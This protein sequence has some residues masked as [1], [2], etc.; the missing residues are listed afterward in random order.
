MTS[1]AGS[2][3]AER[4]AAPDTRRSGV[5]ADHAPETAPPGAADAVLAALADSAGWLRAEAALRNSEAWLHSILETSPDLICVID[6]EGRYRYINSA[7]ERTLGYTPDQLVGRPAR[8]IVHPDDT[9]QLAGRFRLLP[10][11][12]NRRGDLAH[13]LDFTCRTRHADGGWRDMEAK[14]RV[15]TNAD[16]GFGGVLIVSRDVTD[17][18]RMEAALRQSE[19]HYRALAESTSAIVWRAKPDGR[20]DYFNNRWFSFTGLTP[21][22]DELV[23]TCVVHPDDLPAIQRSWAE[24]MAV[25]DAWEMEYRLRGADGVYRWFLGRSVPVQRADHAV[26]YWVGSAIDITERILAEHRQRT[27]YA[28][29]RVLAEATTIEESLTGLLRVLC[30]GL[31]W[32]TGEF[33]QEDARLQT[34]RRACEWPTPAPATIAERFR[35]ETTFRRGEGLPGAAWLSGEPVWQAGPSA[36]AID[37][38]DGADR[39]GQ[40]ST[41][42]FPVRDGHRIIGVLLFTGPGDQAPD[43]PS[44]ELMDDIG[45][46]VGQS[47]ARREAETDR[48]KLLAQE[49]AARLAAQAAAESLRRLQTITDTA[50][51]DL[52]AETLQQELLLRVR[53][54]LGTDAAILYLARPEDETLEVAAASGRD[55]PPDERVLP[56]GAGI[57]GRVAATRQPLIADDVSEAKTVRSVL[58]E[59]IHSL[60]AVPL[61]S[62]DRLLGVLQVGTVLPRR[63][64]SDDVRLLALAADRVA[65]ALERS[66]IHAA[67]QRARRRAEA[68]VHL[69]E[70]TLAMISHDISQPLSV[71]HVSLPVLQQA[72]GALPEDLNRLIASMER[73][74]S[75]IGGM[76]AELL[77]LARLQAGRP[78]ELRQTR[79][80]LLE[81]VEEE[82]AAAQRTADDRP[83]T[84]V[85]NGGK[86]VG[87]WD[88]ARL[89]RV[90][91]NLLANA[92]KYSPAGRP[93]TVSLERTAERRR[94]WAQVRIADQGI[95]IPEQDQP[96]LFTRFQ[97]ASNVGTIQGTGLGLAGAKQ[98]IEQHG[99]SI[100]IASRE[101]EG[102]TVTV[103]L[104]LNPPN[105]GGRP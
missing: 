63:F 19:G 96:H 66:R 81:L 50:L 20:I 88:T 47:L 13:D 76:A 90:F 73:A 99:G 24:A 95:G 43:S 45:R 85:A 104:P 56:P 93:I 34:L 86:I 69:Q 103:R 89:A 40:G 61:I 91:A 68:A 38:R 11:E 37:R 53:A 2:H 7:Y 25:G 58:G 27:R 41:V 94:R 98:I 48:E 18:R 10:T 65:T 4:H 26:A 97:R 57:A 23:W 78:L 62:D 92:I 59:Q 71:L 31:G 3:G 35:P 16:G 79:C 29:T 105:P 12:W 9:A 70:Q 64:T 28:V 17:R 54:A 6:A 80:D 42:A 51:S 49:Q 21:Q 36:D 67:E 44:L 102:T 77:D 100:V 82:V 14:W 52:A 15:L 33:W 39:D 83:I 60:A 5:A 75:R 32:E 87:K 55:I 22:E 84:V 46:Q 1:A 72:L 101:G 74:T 8:E 30:E